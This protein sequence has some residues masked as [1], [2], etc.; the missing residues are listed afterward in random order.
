MVGSFFTL[1][2]SKALMSSSSSSSSIILL[3]SLIGKITLTLEKKYADMLQ[4]RLNLILTDILPNYN[5]ELS[6]ATE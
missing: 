3:K 5:D 6:I 2:S 1:A 4:I